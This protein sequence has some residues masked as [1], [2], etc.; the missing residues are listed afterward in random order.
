M[1]DG[2]GMKIRGVVVMVRRRTMM[3]KVMTM[4][5]RRKLINYDRMKNTIYS[6]AIVPLSVLVNGHS[7]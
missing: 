3:D 7:I 2:R 5:R 1:R 6:R 4:R